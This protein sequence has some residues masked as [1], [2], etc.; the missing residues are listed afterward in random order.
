MLL[1]PEAREF[2]LSLP[3]FEHL[4]SFGAMPAFWIDRHEVTNA[5]FKKFVDAGGY[6]RREYWQE[7][8]VEH[9]QTVAFEIAMARFVD[10]TGRPGPAAW[11][12]A[13]PP[14]G[15]DH[16]PVSG[17]SW[18][19]AA[20]YARFA[21]KLLPTIHHWA[22][23]ADLRTSRWVVPFG[24]FGGQGPAPVGTRNALHGSGAHDMAGNVK[25]WI[26]T[27]TGDGRR[28]ILGGAWDEPAWMFNDPDARAPFDRQRTF[29]FRCVT[30]PTPPSAALVASQPWL[31]RDYRRERPASDADFAIYRRLYAYDRQPLE[32]KLVTTVERDEWRR[33]DVS[34]SAAYGGER[35]Q[36]FL[37]LPKRATPPFETVVFFPGSNAFRTRA[38]DDFPTVNIDF[39]VKSGR[40]VAFPEYKATFSR[41]TNVQDSTANPSVTYRDH[42]IAWVKD[43]SRAVDYLSTRPDLSVDRLALFGISWG[44]RMGSIIPA[45]D[46]RLKV[47]VLVVGGF[48]MQRPMPEVDQVNFATRVTI[49][50]LMLNGRYDFFFPIDTSQQPM[51]DALSTPKD[52]K[53]IRRYDGGHGI[54]RV[55]LIR[56]TLN[57]LDRFQPVKR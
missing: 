17:V 2:R 8:F 4:S 40:A 10:S 55:E 36:V 45:I 33:E 32:P 15:E 43:F 27:D 16:L 54:P 35:M 49:P 9:G 30:Y 28:Y 6:Q 22:R 13:E 1:V 56:E 14:K 52:R 3:G 38:I 31:T 53:D 26:S 48:S 5:E 34:I 46:D 25:E 24:N 29:G 37:F 19:E 21:G 7:P 18:Y 23:A 50:T 39:L 57:W 42:M 51:F 44:G 11:I 20:A 47:Q 12:Q 41:P